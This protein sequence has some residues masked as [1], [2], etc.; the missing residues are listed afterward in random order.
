LL[1]RILN[2]FDESDYELVPHLT[3]VTVVPCEMQDS[4]IWYK[5]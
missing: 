2:K 5:L 1:Y 3:N 4:C